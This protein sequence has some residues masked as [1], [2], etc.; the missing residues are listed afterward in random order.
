VAQR[1]IHG[2][3]RRQVLTH[4]LEVEK[5][6]LQPLADTPFRIFRAGTRSVHPD[7]HVE[8]DTDLYSVPHH[9]VGQQVRVHWEEHLVRIYAGGQ[10]V[11]V[12]L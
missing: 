7:G 9:L 6:L 5:P 10:A 3:T 2:T 4:F 1:R 11:S 8:V 12:H